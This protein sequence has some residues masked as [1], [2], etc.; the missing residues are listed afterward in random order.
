MQGRAASKDQLMGGAG[1]WLEG[2]GGDGE[3]APLGR[4]DKEGEWPDGKAKIGGGL[5]GSGGNA[6]FALGHRGRQVRDTCV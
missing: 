1:T 4:K 3:E 6:G 2:Y 5:G